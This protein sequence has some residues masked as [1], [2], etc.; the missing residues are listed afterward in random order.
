MPASHLPNSLSEVQRRTFLKA[1]G[2]GAAGVGLAP[3]LAACTGASS[4]NSGGG[5]SSSNASKTTTV[6]SNYSDAVPKAAFAKMIG[7]WQNESG[8][9]AT[10]NTVAH[11]DF[12]NNINN[13]LQGSPDDV[14]TWFAGFR[15]RYYAKK[16]L[17]T[18]IDDVWQK[19]GSNMSDAFAKASTGDDGKKYLVPL[20]NY[21][22]AV[23]YRKSVFQSK[24]YQTPTKWDEFVALCQQMKKDGITPIA[25]ADKDQWPALGT[26]DYLDMRLNGYDF[27]IALMA[28]QK[29]W[30]SPEVK[31]VFD[32]WK[33]I[34]PYHDL[35]G[36]LGRT[37]Q[38][39]AQTL[40]NKKTGMYLLGSFVAQQFTGADLQDLDFFTFPEIDPQYGQDAIEAPIDGLMLSKKGA[41]N[42]AAISLLEY[43]GTGKGQSLYIA[44]DPSDVAAAKDADT[45][46]YNAIQKKSADVISKAKNISQFLDRDA[47]PAFA[48]DVM[49]PAL[50]NFIKN[51]TFDAAG[52]EAQAKQVYASTS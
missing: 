18:P 51:Q 15:M 35:N 26:F 47:L 17:V 12:Q 44:T 22:W 31:K 29:S 20:Y 40:L 14:F 11:N 6:G 28:H 27:H 10:I 30:D 38:E 36:A 1:L 48:T 45:S 50:Q 7:G 33:Q 37:W 49:E 39:S 34:L 19:I 43:C 13:Y 2:V 3:L 9:T 46:K 25:F 32:T 24:G 8:D 21:P 5:G 4:G 52:V 42:A 41:G 23:F 16:G